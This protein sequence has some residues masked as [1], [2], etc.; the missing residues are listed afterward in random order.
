[1]IDNTT[2]IMATGPTINDITAEEWGFLKHKHT[3]GFSDFPYSSKKTEFYVSIERE[4]IDKKMLYI[5]ALNGFLDTKLLLHII[6]SIEYAQSLGFRYIAKIYKKNAFFLPSKK[7]WFTDEPEPPHKFMECRAHS[8]HQNLFRFRG[9]LSAVINVALLLGANEIR[10]VGVDLN[11]QKGFY[12]TEY[13]EG[14]N[15]KWVK[16]KDYEQI[17]NELNTHSK[18]RLKEKMKTK[19]FENYNKKTMHT[20]NLLYVD[21]SRWGDRKLRP[22]EDVLEWMNKELLE[23]GKKGIFVSNKKSAL[24]THH[25]LEYKEIMEI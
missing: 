11:C 15:P 25:K 14:I 24:Y 12:E 3:I 2:Y 20:T 16:F 7:P 4:H 5:M 1:M 6:P 13:Q 22:M 19:M 17:Y 18:E 10:L 21:E 9:Q 8:F 23:E